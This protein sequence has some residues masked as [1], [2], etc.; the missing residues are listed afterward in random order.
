MIGPLTLDERPNSLVDG[1]SEIVHGY[2]V[3]F[4]LLNDL[5]NARSHY[6]FN[7]QR[8]VG[9]V[10]LCAVL[11]AKGI[12]SVHPF[13]RPVGHSPHRRPLICHGWWPGLD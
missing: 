12:E 8:V 7:V 13:H 4:V 3:G 2:I 10:F 1:E 5:V 6:L 9:A 11:L